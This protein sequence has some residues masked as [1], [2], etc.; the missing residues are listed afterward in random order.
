MWIDPSSESNTNN[1]LIS[2]LLSCLQAKGQHCQGGGCSQYNRGR[3]CH[4]QCPPLPRHSGKETS[5]CRG[6]RGHGWG[7]SP[8]SKTLRQEQLIP[9]CQAGVTTSPPG[10][11][12]LRRTGHPVAQVPDLSSNLHRGSKNKQIIDSICQGTCKRLY[13]FAEAH[14]VLSDLVP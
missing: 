1:N 5:R 2:Y 12:F 10:V 11:V 3:I 13:R 7:I 6:E 14:V 8:P 4:A 9:Q